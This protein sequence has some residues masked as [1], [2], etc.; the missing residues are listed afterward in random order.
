MARHRVGVELLCDVRFDRIHAQF[1]RRDSGEGEH[2]VRSDD[3][4]F[5]DDWVAE[6]DID[7][8]GLSI[9]QLKK[10]SA[11]GAA[12]LWREAISIER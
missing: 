8:E 3:L 2:I 7:A 11:G 12:R 5:T 4:R 1:G 9:L 6:C 10:L